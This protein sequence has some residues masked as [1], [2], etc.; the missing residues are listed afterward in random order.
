M[1]TNNWRMATAGVLVGFVLVLMP[2][3]AAAHC[4]W[5]HPHH[6][7]DDLVNN[8]IA[9]VI[10]AVLTPVIVHVVEPTIDHTLKPF[11]E[12]V[13]EPVTSVTLEPLLT[14]VLTP[15]I[16][17]AVEG[18]EAV[19]EGV[20]EYFDGDLEPCDCSKPP[21]RVWDLCGARTPLFAG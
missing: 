18:I 5:G 4:T 20:G 3:R 7:A 1:T 19:A 21:R 16:G 8:V 6:C 12:D 15:V 14:E 9:P 17:G 13:V 10:D 11:I 2:A